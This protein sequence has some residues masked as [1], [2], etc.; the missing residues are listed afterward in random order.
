M[1]KATNTSNLPYQDGDLIIPPGESAL[2]DESR[3]NVLKNLYS[4]QFEVSEA[5]E[6]SNDPSFQEVEAETKDYQNP[7]L[8][9]RDAGYVPEEHL[10][11]EPSGGDPQVEANPDAT[12]VKAEEPKT[13][14]SK[15]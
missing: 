4:W 3:A 7:I 1:H 15:K 10:T 9:T 6:G 11:S 2:V 5:Q 12:P 13:S 8:E 14:R